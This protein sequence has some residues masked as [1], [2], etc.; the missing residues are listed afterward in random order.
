MAKSKSPKRKKL[1]LTEDETGEVS[2][3]KKKREDP[4]PVSQTTISVKDEKK[5]R[6]KKKRK[7]RTADTEIPHQSSVP[8]EETSSLED[9]E[10]LNPEEE[11]VLQRKIKKILKKEE[12]DKLKAEG[13]TTQKSEAPGPTASQQALDYLTCW[14]TQRDEW[15]FQKTRQTWLLQHMFDPDMIPDDKFSILLEYMEGL[16]GGAKDTTVQKALVL[17]QESGQAPADTVVQQ[18]AQRAKEV[19]QLLT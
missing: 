13:K 7:K 10:V 4:V 3:K 11:R 18:R 17:V 15:K 12:K 16:R 8:K 19:I 14:S 5:K 6:E 9:K 2:S 1:H